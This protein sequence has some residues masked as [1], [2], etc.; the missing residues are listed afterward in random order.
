MKKKI[1]EE[2]LK[3]FYRLLSIPMIDFNCG[4]LCAPGNN[5]IPV[6]CEN[7]GVVPILFHEEY[8]WHW[9]NG[10]FWQRMPPVT[11]EI[12]KFI[13]ESEDYY[14]FAKCPGPAGCKRSKRSL[15]CRTFPLEPYVGKDGE[16]AGLAYADAR[17]INC[18]LI[19]KP[20]KLFN[21]VF[22]RNA[23]KFWEEMFE[24]YPEEKEMYIDESRK[25]DRRLK[26]KGKR[27]SIF[28]KAE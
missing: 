16:V 21:P 2:K 28:S 22:I 24:C 1:T 14:V 25:R 9:K 18:P 3:R 7:E 10:R 23:I 11:K 8:K 20:K 15:N 13:E 19:G 5:G 17:E 4:D 6:C 27:L 26:R 12:K